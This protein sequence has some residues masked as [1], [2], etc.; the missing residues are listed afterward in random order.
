Q[1]RDPGPA[2][3]VA[4][5]LRRARAALPIGLPPLAEFVHIGAETIRIRNYAAPERPGRQLQV[6]VIPGRPR[7]VSLPGVRF[8]APPAARRRGQP[9]A[10]VREAGEHGL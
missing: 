10:R 2:L 7:E 5:G 8:D 3:P 6:R 1:F 4:S 9:L